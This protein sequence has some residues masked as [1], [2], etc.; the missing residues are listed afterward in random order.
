MSAFE[1]ER[2]QT[3]A[4]RIYPRS[5]GFQG[6]YVKGAQAALAGRS[7]DA[8]PYRNRRGWIAWRRA[9]LSGYSSVAPEDD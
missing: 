8:C 3:R 7:R 9:W 1:L 2:A 6:A 4:R 5:S